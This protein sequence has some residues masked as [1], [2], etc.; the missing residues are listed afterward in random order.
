M[1]T[2]IRFVIV[3]LNGM[4]T[5]SRFNRLYLGSCFYTV[6]DM[7]TLFDTVSVDRISS[8]VKEVNLFSLI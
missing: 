5:S 2:S 4:S 6:L 1:Y 3:R 8:F 7:K